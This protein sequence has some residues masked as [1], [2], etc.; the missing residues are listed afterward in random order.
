[1]LALLA[2]LACPPA[3]APTASDETT[4]EAPLTRPEA[5]VFEDQEIAAWSDGP[6]G[7]RVQIVVDARQPGSGVMR[8]T[9]RF[10]GLQS[11]M[12]GLRATGVS[13][14][15]AIEDVSVHDPDGKV[16]STRIDGKSIH[17]DGRPREDIIVRYTVRPGGDG[18]HGH[19]GIVQS[20][21]ALFDGRVFLVTDGGGSLRAARAKYLLP[22]GWVVAGPLREHDGWQ[23][24]DP[25]GPEKVH[26]AL[27]SSC[28]GLGDFEGSSMPLGASEVRVFVHGSSSAAAKKEI[29]DKTMKVFTWFHDAL[30]FDPGYPQ[31]IVWSPKVNGRRVY[32]GSSGNGTCM[33]QPTVNT[34][35]FQLMAH[36]IGHAMNKYV[37]AGLTFRERSDRWLME[38]WASY[39]ELIATQGA[40]VSTSS[41]RWNDLYK[42][43]L[44][45]RRDHPE[46][47]FP[48][49]DEPKAKGEA[50]EYLHY[51]KAP[52]VV[53]LLDDWIQ[54]HH[55]KD[56]TTFWKA[57]HDVYGHHQKPFP[58]REELETWVG[59]SLED[60]W[61]IH[62][63]SMG[64]VYPVWPEYYDDK[65]K[66]RATT[67]GAGTIAGRPVSGDYLQY[68]AQTGEFT[69]FADIKAFV[70]QEES[71]RL[72]LEAVGIHLLPPAFEPYRAGLN[73]EARH[74]LARSEANY[75][76]PDAPTPIA[77]TSLVL[78]PNNPDGAAFLTLL[79]DEAR[80][81]AAVGPSGME[82][83]TIQRKLP[84]KEEKDEE[85][86][87]KD[88]DKKEEDTY[89]D[90]VLVFGTKDEVRLQ[91]AWSRTAGKTWVR[92]L[93]GE[94]VLDERERGV[95][96][97][98]TRSWTN[99]EPSKLGA[100][101]GVVS[102]QVETDDGHKVTRSFWRRDP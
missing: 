83:L 6:K 88:E 59:A 38:G 58:M 28:F 22:D 56:L 85:K 31:A 9:Q 29:A 97:L 47:D 53:L 15:V 55:G 70:D 54:R 79:A 26:T 91:A 87:E 11:H 69:R 95:S 73:P 76:L 4:D 99:F 62:V 65:V 25:Y 96:P 63:R 45:T 43:Y 20:D 32:G 3:P 68:L 66:A 61:T 92:S 27:T 21:F 46:Q 72:Q 33:E 24:F 19:Q 34:R 93:R 36:R 30:G 78:D 5:P 8:V 12:W 94:Q 50:T 102:F 74:A 89:S 101:P 1:M 98:W 71:R 77:E 52:L 48:M 44:N 7:P 23:I 2:L 40:G 39:I 49:I 42:T 75:P 80:Y 84:K 41:P 10:E 57:M 14:E 86:G 81:E 37:P 17:L 16:I 100:G 35:A 18:R 51:F 60:F 90:A 64:Y 82:N 13:K 67:P